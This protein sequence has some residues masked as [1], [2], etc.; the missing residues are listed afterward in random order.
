M[1]PVRELCRRTLVDTRTSGRSFNTT[2][3]PSVHR[4]PAAAAV[5]KT[6]CSCSLA[7]TPAT[8]H[9]TGSLGHRVS[10]SFGSS[11]TSR[12]PG[13]HFDPSF[14]GVRKNAQNAKHTFE[15]LKWQRSLSGVL[16]D[17]NHWM[18]VHAMNL[19]FYFYL[20]LLKTLWCENTS[21]HI[22]RYLEFSIEQGHRVNWVS[23]SLDSHKMWPSSICAGHNIRPSLK[24]RRLTHCLGTSCANVWE[25][26]RQPSQGRFQGFAL[27][28]QL[29]TQA[30]AHNRP[31]AP[32]N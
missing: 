6:H 3:T 29:P 25:R 20:W 5:T 4:R 1:T 26:T 17:W 23:G 12:S 30:H 32:F 8:R 13:H 18:S 9:G 11:F 27:G 16:L 19:N 2:S 28:G 14:S 22:S 31:I 24:S 15:M 10:G 21:S 7:G